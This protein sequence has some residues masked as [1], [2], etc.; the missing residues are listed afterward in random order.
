LEQSRDVHPI[1]R[2]FIIM[3][4]SFLIDNNE[5]HSHYV[6]AKIHVEIAEK[7]KEFFFLIMGILVLKKFCYNR[8]FGFCIVSQ[9][10]FS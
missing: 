1:K 2:E 3:S 10:S 7:L 8:Y 5:L 9:I 4:E 6:N